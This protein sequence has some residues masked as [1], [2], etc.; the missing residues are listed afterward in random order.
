MAAIYKGI[1]Y[2]IICNKTQ[3]QQFG[4]LKNKLRTFRLRKKV[5]PLNKIVLLSFSII[6]AFFQLFSVKDS[7]FTQVLHQV[8]YMH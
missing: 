2:F 8:P 3:A 6:A 1:V 7:A 5:Q 4:I